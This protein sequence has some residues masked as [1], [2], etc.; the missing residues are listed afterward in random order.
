M[1]PRKARSTPDGLG[2]AQII[3]LDRNPAAIFAEVFYLLE[4][5]LADMAFFG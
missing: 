5:G 4:L 3:L 2:L 1:R